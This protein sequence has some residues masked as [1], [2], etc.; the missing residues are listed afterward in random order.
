M[1]QGHYLGTVPQDEAAAEEEKARAEE[2]QEE[3]RIRALETKNA[4]LEGDTDFHMEW[5]EAEKWKEEEERREKEERETAL[6]AQQ[7]AVYNHYLSSLTP[8]EQAAFHHL[9][10]EEQRMRLDDHGHRMAAH[11]STGSGHA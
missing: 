5:D 8:T 11:A 9:S 3:E 1:F 6:A 2:R 10:A 7:Q 4:I